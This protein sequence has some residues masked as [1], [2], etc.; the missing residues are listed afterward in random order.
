MV[1]NLPKLNRDQNS[2]CLYGSPGT[3]DQKGSLF[4]QS[5]FKE[6]TKREVGKDFFKADKLKTRTERDYLAT[7]ANKPIEITIPYMVG[8]KGEEYAIE[9]SKGRVASGPPFSTSDVFN[10]EY[11]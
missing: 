9:N 10:D 8:P 1:K 7:I 11:M 2:T 5:W 6:E 4:K 3:N